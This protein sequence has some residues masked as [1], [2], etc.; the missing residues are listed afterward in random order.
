MSI[1]TL[2]KNSSTSMNDSVEFHC[3]QN[4]ATYSI[5][6]CWSELKLETFAFTYMFMYQDRNFA[7]APT[8][9]CERSFVRS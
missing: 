7:R 6:K 2:I 8:V 5:E 3:H 4:N 9:G 1:K